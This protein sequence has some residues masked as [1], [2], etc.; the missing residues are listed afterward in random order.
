VPG[1]FGVLGFDKRLQVAEVHLPEASVLIEPGV[2]GAQRLGVELVNTVPA[3]A[4]LPYQVSAPQQP[5]M[6]GDGGTRDRKGLSD[7]PSGL[8]PPAE[9][10]ENGAAG[11]IGQ[12]LERRFGRICNRTVPH[13]A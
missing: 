3:L 11:R 10:V 1:F 8:A 5:Q 2:Y 9:E 13:N 12:C 4:V 7:F 6:L